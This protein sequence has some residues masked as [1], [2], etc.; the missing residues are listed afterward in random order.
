MKK[1]AQEEKKRWT[2]QRIP[3]ADTAFRVQMMGIG[4]TGF[5]ERVAPS[6]VPANSTVNRVG[7]YTKDE[8]RLGKSAQRSNQHTKLFCEEYSCECC[9]HLLL[10]SL[11][12]WQSVIMYFLY[13]S[14]LQGQIYTQISQWITRQMSVDIRWG[15][16]LS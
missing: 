4:D 7:S 11:P 16:T 15:K 8:L 6:L 1:N 2:S 14:T 5:L 13:Y 10:K 12:I 9:C 3:E